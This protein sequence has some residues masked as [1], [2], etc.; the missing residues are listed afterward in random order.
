[1]RHYLVE[2]TSTIS[3]TLLATAMAA[4]LA[5]AIVALAF[6]RGVAVAGNIAADVAAV[7]SFL[8]DKPKSLA[9]PPPEFGVGSY[10]RQGGYEWRAQRCSWSVKQWS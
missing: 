1:M 8:A 4:H 9:G 10:Y 3:T 6:S 2:T 7:D 5:L